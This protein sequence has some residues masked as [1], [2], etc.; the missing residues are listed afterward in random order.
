MIKRWCA[1]LNLCRLWYIA[2]LTLWEPQRFTPTGRETRLKWLGALLGSFE[3]SAGKPNV[4][5]MARIVDQEI[6]VSP[7]VVGR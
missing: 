4:P 7:W 6:V 5:A 3:A 1:P 2:E